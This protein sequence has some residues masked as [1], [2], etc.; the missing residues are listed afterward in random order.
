[1]LL[2]IVSGLFLLT[3]Y[4]MCRQFD[5]PRDILANHTS[6]QCGRIFAMGPKFRALSTR[7]RALLVNAASKCRYLCLSYFRLQ[8]HSIVPDTQ[9]SLYSLSSLTARPCTTELITEYPLD[10]LHC[11]VAHID[12]YAVRNSG[13]VTK[14]MLQLLE[15]KSKAIVFQGRDLD[16][17]SLADPAPF[18]SQ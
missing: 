15:A 8:P 6:S 10:P 16:F 3:C 4:S 12:R 13:I 2:I 1:M 7:H 5:D 11:P 18:H 9:P 14:Y 17:V